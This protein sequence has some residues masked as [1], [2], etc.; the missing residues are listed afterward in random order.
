LSQNQED[1]NQPTAAWSALLASRDEDTKVIP[2]LPRDLNTA[3]IFKR[4]PA[5]LDGFPMGDRRL[6]RASPVTRVVIEAPY[7]LAAFPTTQLQWRSGI[8]AFHKAGVK[9]HQD[10]SECKPAFSGDYLPMESVNWD[11]CV[12]WMNC[13]MRL[14]HVRKELDNDPKNP[15]ILRLPYEAEWEWACRAV[16]STDGRYQ[17]CTWEFNGLNHFGDGEPAIE[18]CGWFRYNSGSATHRVGQRDP[19]PLGLYDMHG[20]VDEW[21]ADLWMENYSGYWD[22]LTL[23]EVIGLNSVLNERL[24]VIRGGSWGYSA[25]GCLSAFR[26]GWWPG[27]RN[28]LRGF[29]VGLFPGPNRASSSKTQA[30]SEQ[31]REAGTLRESAESQRDGFSSISLPPRSGRNF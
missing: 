19:N 11:D 9:D 22:G 30:D 7:W 21:C 3:M 24:R 17:A 18:R 23:Q 4:V 8:E 5:A 29:R 15:F 20:N 12:A 31:R 10:L 1:N 25:W 27:N 2:I 16:P 14:P 13:L 26:F 28:G 6:D